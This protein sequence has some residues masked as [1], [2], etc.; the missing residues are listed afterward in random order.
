LTLI[1]E[2]LAVY[3]DYFANLTIKNKEKSHKATGFSQIM[4]NIKCVDKN[5]S[6][7]SGRRSY[8]TYYF[9]PLGDINYLWEGYSNVKRQS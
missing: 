5:A 4:L 7:K 2:H 9:I 6:H 1:F 3:S 8:F